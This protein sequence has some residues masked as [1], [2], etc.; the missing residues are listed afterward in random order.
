M[1]INFDQALDR[2]VEAGIEWAT[3]RAPVYGAV[4]GYVRLPDDHP[5]R[6]IADLQAS[7]ID[8]HGGITYGVDEDGWIGFDTLHAGDW[9]PAMPFPRRRGDRVWNEYL[10]ADEAR[11]LARLAAAAAGPMITI[12]EASS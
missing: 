12:E 4:N 1:S 11:E 5:W 7:G 6:A 3:L 9:W 8:A 10:V 2:G